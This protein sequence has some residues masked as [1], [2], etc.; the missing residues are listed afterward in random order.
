[1]ANDTF[2]K[3]ARDDLVRL[4]VGLDYYRDWKIA[5]RER[6]KGSVTQEDL[7]E[8]VMPGASFLEMFDTVPGRGCLAVLKDIKQWYSH[9]ASDLIYLSHVDGGAEAP[10]IKQ[11]LKDFQNDVGFDF[12]SEAG[13]LEKVAKTVLKKGK[14]VR[15]EEY[16]CLKEL[17]LD[18]SQTVLSA[19]DLDTVSALLR[20]FER[21]T[22]TG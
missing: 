14:V 20:D 10:A 7:N 5:L 12:F 17:E 21:R 16:F 18:L 11:F 19:E 15:E 6:A 4:L 3:T 13:V 9:T 2:R 8:I 1:M 22:K